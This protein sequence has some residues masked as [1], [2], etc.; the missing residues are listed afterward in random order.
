MKTKYQVHQIMFGMLDG[1]IIS[2]AIEKTE[3]D[4]QGDP[5]VQTDMYKIAGIL[6]LFRE[7]EIAPTKNMLYAKLKGVNYIVDLTAAGEN[8]LELLPGV[9]YS[10]INFEGCNFEQIALEDWEGKDVRGSN[11]TDASLAIAVTKE[12]FKAAV[13]WDETTLWTDG[14]TLGSPALAISD[15]PA[16][17]AHEVGAEVFFMEQNEPVTGVVKATKSIVTDSNNDNTAEQDDNYTIEGFPSNYKASKLFAT[18]QALED[19]LDGL[20]GDLAG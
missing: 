19:D 10:A 4:I 11:F 5:E 20:I 15:K 18:A 6:R 1:G 2:G 9:D 7:S 13:T 14:L 12:A 16:A 17:T 8:V 3:T